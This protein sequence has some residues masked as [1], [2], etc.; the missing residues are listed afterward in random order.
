MTASTYRI[1]DEPV[2]GTLSRFIVQP[3]WPLLALM[4]SGAW[5]AWPWFVF[6]SVAVGS[7]TLRREVLLVLAALATS[8]ATVLLMMLVLKTFGPYDRIYTYSRLA[9][10]VGKIVFGYVLYTSQAGSV[11]L[12]EHFHRP[13]QSGVWVVAGAWLADRFVSKL[14]MGSHE[15]VWAALS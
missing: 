8:V 4:F 13:P 14:L 7:A 6:N 1:L 15:F 9:I 10:V 5:I 3:F 2:P 11:A 12:Y